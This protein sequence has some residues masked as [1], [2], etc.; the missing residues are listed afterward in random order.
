MVWRAD[1]HAFDRKVT[2]DAIGGLNLGFPGQYHD[3]ETGLWQ[4]GFRNYDA[5][6][7]RYVETDPIGL[8]GGLNTYAYVANNPVVGVDPLGLETLRCARELGNSA[9]APMSPAGNPLRHDFL[10]SDGKVYSFQMGSNAIASQGRIDDGEKGNEKCESISTDPE[11]DKAVAQAVKEIGA[12][13]Y[14]V[15]AYP[16]TLGYATGF[17]NCQSWATNVLARA[18]EIHGGK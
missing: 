2:L 7:G 17:R 10:I 13:R 8:A 11:F 16:G 4:N 5:S 18:R 12:P 3:V 6:L 1:N 14:N 15:A 9:G